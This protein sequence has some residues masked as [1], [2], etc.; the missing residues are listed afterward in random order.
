M[1][2]LVLG[3]HRSLAYGQCNHLMPSQTEP[4][5]TAPRV[6][7]VAALE[8]AREEAS[9][10]AKIG[11]GFRLGSDVRLTFSRWARSTVPQFADWCCIDLVLSE[12][13]IRREA[14]AFSSPRHESTGA[15]MRRSWAPAELPQELRDLFLER[16]S[17]RSRLM[18]GEECRAQGF[19]RWLGVQQVA[20]LLLVPIRFQ[21]R[22]AGVMSW[23]LE[24]SR[25]SFHQD[26]I[27][28]AEDLASRIAVAW[29]NARTFQKTQAALHSR[30]EFVAVAAHE[31]KNPASVL[32]L[33]IQLLR[34]RLERAGAETIPVASVKKAADTMERSIDSLLEALDFLLDT[35]RAATGQLTL[36]RETFELG[37][38]VR[39]V[40]ERQ[41]FAL[42]S[43]HSS[44]FIN[45]PSEVSGLWDRF[46]IEQVVTNLVSNAIKYAPGHPIG[47]EV[48]DLGSEV[49]LAV[50]DRGRGIPQSERENIFERFNRIDS[51][52]SL[53]GLGLGLFICRQIIELHGGR[54]WVEGE[55]GG[56]ARFVFRIPRFPSGP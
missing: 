18:T 9:F 16:A 20:Q 29:E 38:L 53:P 8:L 15:S 35:T 13:E 52:R 4:T 11:H 33:Q 22:P 26:S 28:V 41:E 44:V 6:K 40:I 49:L 24:D 21:G 7:T 17:N 10:L 1:W 31:L 5:Q 14:L 36:K 27:A 43:A 55:E 2:P 23:V 12:G 46:R 34:G 45:A 54:I 56:G 32:R 39:G 19:A 25:R 51:T 47:I 37:A 48:Q 3:I 42:K 50:T 30:E